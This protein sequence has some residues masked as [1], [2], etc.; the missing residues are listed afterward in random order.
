MITNNTRFL[1]AVHSR[2]IFLIEV[3]DRIGQT[4]DTREK[5]IGFVITDYNGTGGFKLAS[6]PTDINYQYP[7]GT[8][9]P[10]YN[11]LNVHFMIPFTAFDNKLKTFL[12]KIRKDTE[13]SFTVN[14][15]HPDEKI[16][17]LGFEKHL[18][19][20]WIGSESYLIASWVGKQGERSP[21]QYPRPFKE[22]GVP[23]CGQDNDPAVSQSSSNE[24]F[25]NYNNN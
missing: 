1:R 7:L 22:A 4:P 16:N 5:F 18:L 23:I 20:G 8:P 6:S 12:F 11:L 13:V 17:A 24:D 10:D 2:K 25:S 3:I 9:T 21:V 14:I 19:T 15:N